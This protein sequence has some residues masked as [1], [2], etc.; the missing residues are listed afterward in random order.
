MV[1]YLLIEKNSKKVRN[2]GKTGCH[3]C[4][5]I[6]YQNQQ[7]RSDQR[8]YS[9]NKALVKIYTYRENQLILLYQFICSYGE[10]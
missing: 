7:C 9:N 3:L 4:Y 5:S 8:T 1:S 2:Y 6:L 10:Q